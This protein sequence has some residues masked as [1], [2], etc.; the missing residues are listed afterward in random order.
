VNGK[1]QNGQHLDFT[2]LKVQQWLKD[3][4]YEITS[5]QQLMFEPKD[6]KQVEL[7][8]EIP[9]NECAVNFQYYGLTLGK[10][11]KELE[12]RYELLDQQYKKLIIAEV[13]EK[14]PV[15][16]IQLEGRSSAIYKQKRAIVTQLKAMIEAEKTGV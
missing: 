1:Q 15:K 4:P 9:V 3:C 11:T 5:L 13:K 8:V 7:V 16:L 6:K 10:K 2:N 14:N 12:E